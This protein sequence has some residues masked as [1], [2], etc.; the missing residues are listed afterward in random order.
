MFDGHSSDGCLPG[1]SHLQASMRL[2]ETKHEQTLSV[3]YVFRKSLISREQV[4]SPRQAALKDR[5]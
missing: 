4:E 2:A 3:P 1:G 5:A